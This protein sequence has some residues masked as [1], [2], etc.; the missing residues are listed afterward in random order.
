MASYSFTAPVCGDFPTSGLSG[1]LNAQTRR[2]LGPVQPD[3]RRHHRRRR[4]SVQGPVPRVSSV[5]VMMAAVLR[6][7][8]QFRLMVLVLAAGILGFG[9]T[10][11]ASHVRGCFPGIR[12]PQVEIQTEALGLSAAEVEQLITSPMEAD[13][14]NGVAWVEAIRSKSV[15]G[16]SSIQMVFQPGTDIFRARQLV[17]ERL[18]QARALPNVS[19]APVLMQPLS[20]TSRVMMVRL[21]SKQMSAIEMS[22]LARWTM[23]P[24]SWPYPGLRTS[25]SGA[26]ATNSCRFWWI[27]SSFRPRG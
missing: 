1:V 26:S 22:V 16:L 21:T 27:P 14:L 20:S 2:F 9:F 23:K 12:P 7:V 19:A 4:K 25:L 11:F 13:L 24:G 18:T 5:P 8:L 17:A 3:C 15:P 10:S 6:W